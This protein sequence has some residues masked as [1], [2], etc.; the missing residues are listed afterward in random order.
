MNKTR[1]WTLALIAGLFGAGDWFLATLP[2]DEN[3]L[4]KPALTVGNAAVSAAVRDIDAGGKKEKHLF[5]DL[6][7]DGAGRIKL[8][9]WRTPPSNRMSRMLPRPAKVWER[10]IAV[11]TSRSA[12]IDLGAFPDGK[13]SLSAYLSASVDGKAAVVPI[14]GLLAPDLSDEI[15]APSI[16]SPIRDRM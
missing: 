2:A 3:P 7:G 10:D 16:Q 12:S 4:P 11:D 6:K 9:L 13:G 15:I 5:L 1:T 8:T 14:G